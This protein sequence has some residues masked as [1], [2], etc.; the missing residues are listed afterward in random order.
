MET[1]FAHHAIIKHEESQGIQ[2]TVRATDII[3]SFLALPG[4]LPSLSFLASYHCQKRVFG[5]GCNCMVAHGNVKSLL[6]SYPW[7]RCWW[8]CVIGGSPLSGQ[9]WRAHISASIG[10]IANITKYKLNKSAKLKKCDFAKGILQKN[11]REKV[12]IFK[13]SHLLA[14]LKRLT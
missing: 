11:R 4:W 9:P 3:S 12:C 14:S 10:K 1:K 2:P 7:K 13:G 8:W 5:G 6:K